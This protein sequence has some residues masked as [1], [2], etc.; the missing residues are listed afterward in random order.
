MYGN[1]VRVEAS[2]GVIELSPARYQSVI[3]ALQPDLYSSLVDEI[4]WEASKKRAVASVNRTL[5]WLDELL[6]SRQSSA[7]EEV[8]SNVLAPV[9]GGSFIEERRRSASEASKRNVAGDALCFHIWAQIMKYWCA[10]QSAPSSR[11]DVTVSLF[12]CFWCCCT[13]FFFLPLCGR[14]SMGAV[15][16]AATKGVSCRWTCEP[17]MLFSPG[18]SVTTLQV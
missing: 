3:D 9:T 7:G 14:A 15:T 11:T 1:G 17:I 5:K 18:L 12:P 16:T 6:S 8:R 13:A 4:T 10:M 2:S